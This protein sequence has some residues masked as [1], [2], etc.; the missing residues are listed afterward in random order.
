ME[1]IG[2]IE[3]NSGLMFTKV[4][5]DVKSCNAKSQAIDLSYSNMIQ[6][7][8]QWPM[9]DVAKLLKISKGSSCNLVL[10]DVDK[11]LKTLDK[12]FGYYESASVVKS[13]HS[14]IPMK[15]KGYFTRC[16]VFQL[17]SKDPVLIDNSKAIN[18]KRQEY[19]KEEEIRSSLSRELEGM[20]EEKQMEYLFTDGRFEKLMERMRDH[21]EMVQLCEQMKNM[22]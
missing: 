11:E 17:Y 14:S 10:E 2:F 9:E 19:A 13:S 1:R 7:G 20:S 5:G 12:L 3:S 22:K 16:T 18:L 8:Q 6:E 21:P 4:F 15:W